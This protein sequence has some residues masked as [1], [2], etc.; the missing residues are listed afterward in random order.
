[1]GNNYYEKFKH[2]EVFKNHPEYI[3]YVGENY[4]QTRILLIGESHY[5]PWNELE[6]MKD[7]DKVNLDPYRQEWYEKTTDEIFVAEDDKKYINHFT[8]QKV[9]GAFTSYYHSSYYKTEKGVRSKYAKAYDMFSNPAKV[10]MELSNDKLPTKVSAIKTVAFCNYF[11][12]PALEE[13][14]TIKVLPCDSENAYEAFKVAVEVLEPKLV[15]FL[16]KKAYED[17]EKSGGKNG[18]NSVFE[19]D[20][21]NHPT[22]YSWNANNGKQKFTE[23]LS[24]NNALANVKPVKNER[25]ELLKTLHD[26]LKKSLNSEKINYTD[27]CSDEDI[28]NF[29]QAGNNTITLIK[30]NNGTE[31]RI[32]HYPYLHFSKKKYSY[33][34]TNSKEKYCLD[35]KDDKNPVKNDNP[36]FKGYN[37]AYSKLF[38]MNGR[39]EFISKCIETI[40]AP[41]WL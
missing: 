34:T 36:N 31:F 39:K 33:M 16:S 37:E 8:T 35:D 6:H 3:P 4:E 14:D 19:F 30:F 21:V 17:W 7:K 28:A 9:L 11:Q 15:V 23:I 24:M 29:Y 2:S 22:A 10:M 13:G 27:T 32:T 25:V 1:M 40:K 26:E 38:T 18:I 5:I 20:Y 41:N 12:R